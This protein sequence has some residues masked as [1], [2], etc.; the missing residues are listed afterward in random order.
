MRFLL[1]QGAAIFLC[2]FA[3]RCSES[4]KSI[5]FKLNK[6]SETDLEEIAGEYQGNVE[7][8]LSEN[9]HFQVIDFRPI[10]NPFYSYHATVHF[11]YFQDIK[12]FQKRTYLYNRQQ[13]VWENQASEYKFSVLRDS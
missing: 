13:Q 3:I 2:F 6:I 1:I 7:Y 10:S 5:E 12:V 9:R 8:P 4:P 11:Y